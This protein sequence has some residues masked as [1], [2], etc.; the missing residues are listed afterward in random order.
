MARVKEAIEVGADTRIAPPAA[1]TDDRRY[2]RGTIVLVD[3]G[4]RFHARIVAVIGVVAVI[5]H[6]PDDAAD[7]ACRSVPVRC[8]RPAGDEPLGRDGHA[9]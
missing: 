9:P 8:C 6:R 4:S 5:A 2:P 7:E 1:G 3:D